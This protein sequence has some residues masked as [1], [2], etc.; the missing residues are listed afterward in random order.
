MERYNGLSKFLHWTIGVSIIGLLAIGI[1]MEGLDYSDDKMKLYGLHKAIGILVLT[2]MLIRVFWR[3]ASRH[4]IALGT[5]KT[6]EKILS[7]IVHVILYLMAFSM[8]LSGWAMSSSYGYPVSIFGLFTIPNL[9][10]KDVV[11]GEL[12]T[13]I[14]EFGGYAMIAVIVLHVVGALK[15]HVIDKDNT[16]KRMLPFVR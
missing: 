7:K 3:F 4:P 10:D 12:L 6:W 9:V 5:H 14:H 15:H 8:P 16:L 11:R 2:A 13:K 1:Y